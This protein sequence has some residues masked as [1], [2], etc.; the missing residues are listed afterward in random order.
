MTPRI[1]AIRITTT[2]LPNPFLSAKGSTK[3]SPTISIAQIM[4]G[5]TFIDLLHHRS[6]LLRRNPNAYHFAVA[7]FHFNADVPPFAPPSP[8]G[9]AEQ[10]PVDGYRLVPLPATFGAFL[11]GDFESLGLGYH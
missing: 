7:F 5:I 9:V 1:I 6:R 3:N 10:T 11:F 2:S 4:A 8:N